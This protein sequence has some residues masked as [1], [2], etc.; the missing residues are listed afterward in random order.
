MYNFLSLFLNLQNANLLGP[1]FK[2]QIEYNCCQSLFMF[3]CHQ[4]VGSQRTILGLQK[5]KFL[6]IYDN[7]Q[8]KLLYKYPYISYYV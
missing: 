4:N 7:Y 3:I 5:Y 1:F 8:T 2:I 6:P